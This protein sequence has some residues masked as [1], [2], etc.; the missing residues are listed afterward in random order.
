M[1]LLGF[2]NWRFALCC[3]AAFRAESLWLSDESVKIWGY[4]SD[5]EAQPQD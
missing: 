4:A 3:F 2:A 5:F 1:V